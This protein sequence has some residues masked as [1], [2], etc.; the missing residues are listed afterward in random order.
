MST[1]QDSLIANNIIYNSTLQHGI[2]LD[3][4]EGVSSGNKIINN[5]LYKNGSSGDPSTTSDIGLGAAGDN[6]VTNTTVKNN[7][8]Y[9]SLVG[10]G[11]APN[12]INTTIDYNNIY[13]VDSGLVGNWQGTLAPTLAEWQAL[14]S[15]SA[16]SLS[17]DPA[18]TN[19]TSGSE[20]FHLLAT[21]S[22]IDAGTAVSEDG[23]TVDFESHDRPY[24]TSSVDI[25]A[26]ET[27]YPAVPAGLSSAAITT[28]GATVSWTASTYGEVTGYTVSYGTDEA[29]SN[30]GTVTATTTS[31]A[32]ASLSSN[33]TYYAKVK[34]TNAN[35]DSAYSDIASFTTLPAVPTSLAASSILATGATL[36]WT[37]PSGTITSYTLQYDTN[38]DFSNATTVTE[39]TTASHVLA[40][41]TPATT[42]YA[43]VKATASGGNSAY[44]ESLSFMT[45]SSNIGIIT[46]PASNGGDHVMVYDINGQPT[47]NFRAYSQ[48]ISNTGLKVFSADIDGNSATREIITYINVPGYGPHIRAFTQTGNLMVGFFPYSTKFKGGVEV[49]A[50]DFDG[51]GIN[52]LAVVPASQGGPQLRV[53]NYFVN[54]NHFVLLDSAFVFNQAWR[55]NLKVAAGDVNN[56][57]K[58]EIIIYPQ[59][60]AGPH[61]KV[62]E[63]Y[64]TDGQHNLQLLTDFLAYDT[65]FR[66]GINL[67]TGDFNGDEQQDLVIAP[68]SQGGPNIRTYTFNTTSQSF[69]L[70]DWF[71]A[72]DENFHGGVNLATGDYNGDGKDD[73]ATVPLSHGGP[74][75]R[76]YVLQNNQFELLDWFWAYDENFHGGANLL[77]LDLN[78]D[79]QDEL[80]TA[81]RTGTPNT[82][83]YSQA[84]NAFTLTKWFWAFSESFTGGVNLG[85]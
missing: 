34:A 51:D 17:A 66:G 27:L 77:A 57:G 76:T 46:T 43:K 19:I 44:S 82:R 28:S 49:T 39:V 22:C 32:L 73:L 47:V 64:A 21:S 80:V 68:M 12:A 4:Y 24:S 6:G 33:T 83:I 3:G 72:Y 2:Y 62:Y 60:N 79:A 75:V 38:S 31:A 25:G 81:P 61:V 58:D 14:T 36:S 85:K 29:A 10:I 84:N 30:V 53:Y 69:E 59:T 13:P 37:A 74:N 15:Q 45:L 78:Q 26:D 70:L 16:N 41:L 67:V 48:T 54:E 65:N 18:F 63:T 50:G 40:S 56:N 8:I 23:I 7:A 52:E 35:G 1:V 71:W 9:T 20:D 42:Y 5:T 55:L 11:V